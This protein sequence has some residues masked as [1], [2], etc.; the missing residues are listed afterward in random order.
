M[1][2]P[3]ACL[4]AGWRMVTS[5]AGG[6]AVGETLDG[7]ISRLEKTSDMPGLDAQVLLAR[8][9]DRPRSWVLAHPEAP[10]TG[11]R[12]TALEALVGRLEGGEP[13]PYIVGHWEFFGLEFEVTPDVLIPRPETE[14]LVERA[15]T[16]LRSRPTLKRRA[17]DTKS[18]E[19]DWE[20]P[21]ALDVGTGSGCIAIAL[22]VNTPELR[23]TATDISSA[24]LRVARRNSE[25]LGVANRVTFLES[26]LI[27][28]TISPNSLLPDPLL[29]T[30]FSLIVANLPYIPTNTLYKIPVY[31]REPTLALDGGSDGL[32]LIRR[33]LTE[34]P[35]R[36]I[37]GGLFLMEIEAS[38]GPAVLSLA[39]GAFPKARIHLHKDLAGHDRLLEIKA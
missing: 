37:S 35:D 5:K 12:Y 21:R 31:G 39:Y 29:P 38:A 33:I 27:P 7:L 8:L 22:A 25:R 24:A 14:L 13:L 23:I 20:M 26:D 30:S 32:V 1:T 4:P 6:Q 34:A 3:T 9:L 10:L 18:A 19:T 11:N 2:R 28:D 36:L 16:W 15:L 17:I